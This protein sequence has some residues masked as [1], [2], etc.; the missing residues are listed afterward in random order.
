LTLGL[1][2]GVVGVLLAW[3]VNGVAT[4]TMNWD[5]FTEQAFAFRITSDVILQAVAFS[6]LIG[7][8]AGVIPAWRASRL[9]PSEALRR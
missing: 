2:G 9:P 3:P 1:A 6:T 4:G 7:V 5:T 8:A